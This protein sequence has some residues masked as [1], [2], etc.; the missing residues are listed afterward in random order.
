M[1]RLER[2]GLSHP[3]NFKDLDLASFLFDNSCDDLKNSTYYL[4]AAQSMSID[5]KEG[6]LCPCQPL[7]SGSR[8]VTILPVAGCTGK[9]Q[10]KGPLNL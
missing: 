4:A 8:A 6:M 3:V 9:N 5:F 2:T 10:E 1:P 7:H